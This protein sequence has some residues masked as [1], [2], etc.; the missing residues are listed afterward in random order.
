MELNQNSKIM[1]VPALLFC[2]E[3]L[4]NTTLSVK[5]NE[6]CVALASKRATSFDRLPHI[7]K[8]MQIC[9]QHTATRHE[10]KACD[11]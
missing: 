2:Y 10:L 9:K 7:T 4:V 6:K 5:L 1:P 8:A 11:P 3:H